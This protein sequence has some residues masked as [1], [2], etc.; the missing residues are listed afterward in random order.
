MSIDKVS[1]CTY[2]GGGPCAINFAAR[3]PDRINCLILEAA[4]SGSW[5]DPR[6]AKMTTWSMKMAS[7]SPFTARFIGWLAKR[8]P[9]TFVKDMMMPGLATHNA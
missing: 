5:D 1:V 7:T 8:S 6:A 9:L 4:N 2:S 3:H